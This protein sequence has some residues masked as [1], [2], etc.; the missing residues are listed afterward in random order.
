LPLPDFVE[1]LSTALGDSYTVERE[2]LG[3]AMSRVFVAHD[4]ALGRRVAVKVL[5]REVAAE[6]K[7]ERF[8]LEIQLAARLQHPHI[9]PLLQSG[10]LNGILYFTMPFI[11]GESLRTKLAREGA[12]PVPDAIR[13]LRH[14]ASAIAYA[15]RQGVVHRDIKPD[16]VLLAEEFAL[17][18][19]FGVARA[20]S[21]STTAGDDRLTSSGVALGTPAYMSPE[22]ALADPE[23]DHRADI[24]AF[25]VLAYEIFAGHPPFGGKSAQATLAAHVVQPPENILTKRPDVPPI[26]AETIMKCLEK[27]PGD[28]PQSA[29]EL[30]PIFDSVATGSPTATSP[31]I[32][33]A[34][35]RRAARRLI[36]GSL[37]AVILIAATYLAVSRRGASELPAQ[38]FTSVA[39]LPLEN[40]GGDQAD[41]YF[42]EGMTDELANALG[43]LPGVR[44]A[45]RTSAYAFKGKSLD[46]AEI[47]RR[48]NVRTFISGKVRRDGPRLRV[49]AQL[50]NVDDGS[51]LWAD[52][53]ERETRDIFT[54][55]DDIARSIAQAL[56]VRLGRHTAQTFASESRGTENLAAWDNFILGRFN[57]NRRGAASLLRAVTYFDSAIARD[58]RF[59]R[60]H[61]GRAMAYALLPEYTD[62]PPGNASTLAHQAAATALS[63][64]PTLGEA[65]TALGLAEVHDW[66]FPEAY[67]A[68]R[69]ALALDPQFPTAHQWY[70]E[71]L[72]HTGQLDSSIAQIRTAI[73]LDPLAPVNAS[74]IG[75]ALLVSRRYDE[76]IAELKK[77][78]EL[79]PTLGLHHAILGDAYLQSGRVQLAIPEFE[80]ALRLEPELQVRKGFLANAYGR[81]GQVE[82]ARPIISQLEERNK[83]R[84]GGGVGL[85]IAYLGLG[86]REQALT[87]LEQAV[88]EHDISLITAASLVPDGIFDSVRNDPR[89]TAI[90]KNMNLDKYAAGM[91]RR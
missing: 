76:A 8:R 81:S 63:I 59:A 50:V 33:P 12:L 28:R 29:S 67:A 15:H 53:Y 21:A 22:Q 56:Q 77:G 13:I 17:V 32:V 85:A 41:E 47:G 79:A 11:E 90:L 14:V 26:L 74:A 10:E 20:L 1:S 78:I 44:V 73:E 66:K 70:G 45:S 48:L 62:S 86:D 18:T 7:T 51:E 91:Q 75:Y 23:I 3:G 65:Y 88:R 2:L 35:P 27:K 31:L 58:P 80:I 16:N 84:G 19:D 68:Y 82:K 54:V 6:V 40:V 60:A 24:Y 42:S 39:V 72:F 57:L 61:A 69:K 89:F 52:T 36:W 71:L 5:S 49:T 9:V 43:K 64:D 34:P 83:M 46:P 30:V 25:G 37:A 87:S 38:N 4:R 55:Q